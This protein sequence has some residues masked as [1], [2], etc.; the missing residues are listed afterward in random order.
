M[1]HL[2]KSHHS[3]RCTGLLLLVEGGRA[4]KTGKGALQTPFCSQKFAVCLFGAPWQ[5]LLSPGR[6][7]VLL[8]LGLRFMGGSA[9]KHLPSARPNHSSFILHQWKRHTGA[10]IS[11]VIK[12]PNK[13]CMPNLLTLSSIK[14]HRLRTLVLSEAVWV[15]FVHNQM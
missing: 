13:H 12:I 10:F 3:I 14:A 9:S 2:Y 15:P 1:T 5:L 7:Q 8:L 6:C 11:D 4:K